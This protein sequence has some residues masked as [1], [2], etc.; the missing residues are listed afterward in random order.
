MARVKNLRLHIE[1]GNS[2]R[3]KEL[4]KQEFAE[5]RAQLETERADRE[6]I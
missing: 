3:E 1:L 4:L 2:A 5:L 6:G